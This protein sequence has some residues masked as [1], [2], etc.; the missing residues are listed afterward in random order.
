MAA[1]YIPPRAEVDR[2]H[3]EYEE[4]RRARAWNRENTC[5]Q[6]IIVKICGYHH[7]RVR[8]LASL[9][10]LMELV[11][12]STNAYDRHTVKV[13]TPSIE[14]ISRETLNDETRPYPRR[15]TVR[16]I[17]NKTVRRVP[18]KYSRIL[19]T[20]LESGK[21]VRAHAVFTGNITNDGPNI[22][23]GPK[24]SSIYFLDIVED[25]YYPIL[26]DLCSVDGAIHVRQN[27]DLPR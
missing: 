9:S 14:N 16:D 5:T 22:G 24:L 1:K 7:F 25:H 2:L 23:G 12:E 11:R 20:G 10:M 8:P 6:I 17:L 21:I 19:S 15:Q 18:A 26:N 4:I 3:A 13:I 27:E